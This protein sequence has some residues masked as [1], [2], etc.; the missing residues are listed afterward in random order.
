MTKE[1]FIQIFLEEMDDQ[2]WAEIIWERVV[3][4]K[5]Q[6]NEE[7]VRDLAK[8]WKQEVDEFGH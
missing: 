2:E 6:L 8:E 5:V 3:K 1:R 7:Q 4:T